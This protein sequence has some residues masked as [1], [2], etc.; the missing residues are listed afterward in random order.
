MVSFRTFRYPLFP[1]PIS[2]LGLIFAISYSIAALM[3]FFS[4]VFSLSYENMLTY[5]LLTRLLTH[6]DRIPIL[7]ATCCL[8]HTS[9]TFIWLYPFFWLWGNMLCN[10]F[11]NL[12]VYIFQYKAKVWFKLLKVAYNETT[13]SLL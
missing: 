8:V 5:L 1:K 6:I 9:K 12:I 11:Q 13:F 7:E 3:L 2:C 4:H 10:N